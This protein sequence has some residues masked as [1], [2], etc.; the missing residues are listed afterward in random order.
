MTITCVP[1]PAPYKTT[2]WAYHCG[3][4]NDPDPDA[5][6]F[7]ICNN[8]KQGS[9]FHLKDHVEPDGDD[10]IPV[11]KA[12]PTI[13]GDPVQFVELVEQLIASGMKILPLKV[14]K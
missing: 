9:H 14:K 12:D 8:K 5:L 1:G 10:H 3:P 11:G 2:A 13:T 6:Y 4:S 7:R